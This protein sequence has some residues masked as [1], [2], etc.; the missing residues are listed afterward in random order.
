MAVQKHIGL[1]T[2]VSMLL[3]SVQRLERRFRNQLF[4]CGEDDSGNSV[5]LKMKYYISYMQNNRDDS[6]LYIFDGEFAEVIYAPC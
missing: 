5:K 6:P 2:A 3:L 4:K 1:Y